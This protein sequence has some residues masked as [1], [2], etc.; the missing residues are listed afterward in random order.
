[1]FGIRLV[2]TKSKSTA[3]QVVRYQDRKTVV[4]KHIGSA[5]KSSEVGLL[6]K[7]ATAW[8]KQHN[9][10]LPLFAGKDASA[11][12]GLDF[13]NDPKVL[14]LNKARLIS[15]HSL[16][17]YEMLSK[18]SEYLGFSKLLVDHP[19]RKLLLDLVI[20]RLIHPCSKLESIQ[21][22]EEEF[23]INYSRSNVYRSLCQVPNFL[24][25][26]SEFFCFV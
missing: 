10:Q 22:L 4:L 9:P 1:M 23:G 7:V 19:Q 21:F 17:V 3:V 14:V 11:V 26:E 18:V 24:N 12:N 15:T 2:K 6:K 25:A 5:K 13:P 16:F 8:I 20:V